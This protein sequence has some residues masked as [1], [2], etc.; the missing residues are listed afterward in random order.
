MVEWTELDTSNEDIISTRT[1]SSGG[2][3]RRTTF[4]IVILE[5]MF[6]GR[7]LIQCSLLYTLLVKETNAAKF[8]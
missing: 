7:M 2:R 6:G 5:G 4:S 1:R 8:T 3:V